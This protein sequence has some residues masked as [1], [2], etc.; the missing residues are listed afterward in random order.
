MNFDKHGLK[1]LLARALSGDTVAWNEFFAEIR[2][3]LH[4]EIRRLLGPKAPGGIDGS[5]LVQST[6]LRIWKRIG[7]QF[8]D[9]PEQAA[10]RRFIGWIKVIIRN[11][12][13]EELRKKGGQNTIPAGDE[14]NDFVQPQ[15]SMRWEQQG[16]LAAA[17]AVALNK[18]P[19]KHRQVV[20]LHWFE[21]LSDAEISRRLGCSEGAVRV[22]RFRALRKLGSAELRTL[23]EECHDSRC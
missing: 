3:Y 7:R 20:E 21:R 2:R 23:W 4:S 6:L 1:P 5:A 14:V 22:V 19:E 15:S 13:W 9:V 12:T 10:I 11:R 8:Q 17:L 18:L 16:R